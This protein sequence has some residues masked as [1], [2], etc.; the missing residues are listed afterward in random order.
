M[1]TIANLSSVHPEKYQNKC[2]NNCTICEI[3]ENCSESIFMYAMWIQQSTFLFEIMAWHIDETTVHL[4]YYSGP[5][6]SHIG[7][8]ATKIDHS[9]DWKLCQHV[10]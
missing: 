1:A 3:V 8:T 7:V 4:I 9:L 5:M 2:P 6:N 10:E